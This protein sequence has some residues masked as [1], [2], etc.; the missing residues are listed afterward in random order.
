MYK[1]RRPIDATF[2]LVFLCSLF[3]PSMQWMNF[4]DWWSLLSPPKVASPAVL[5]QGLDCCPYLQSSVTVL[6]PAKLSCVALACK[7]GSISKY[8]IPFREHIFYI[9]DSYLVFTEMRHGACTLSLSSEKRGWPFLTKI[10]FTVNICYHGNSLINSSIL[11]TL[12]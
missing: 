6:E 10:F 4:A 5:Y 12:F 1:Y 9:S 2:F 3:V 7:G 8:N 11:G